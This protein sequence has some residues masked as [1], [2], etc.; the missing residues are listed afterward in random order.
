M[1]EIWIRSIARAGGIEMPDT[2]RVLPQRVEMPRRSYRE[3]SVSWLR[4]VGQRLV[5]A[6]DALARKPDRPATCG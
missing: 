6:A 4:L 1:N 2:V 5:Q 3:R